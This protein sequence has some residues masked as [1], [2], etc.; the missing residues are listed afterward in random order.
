MNQC[1]AS[2]AEHAENLLDA[3]L[4]ELGSVLDVDEMKRLSGIQEVWIAYRD[5][6]CE[7]QASD[8]PIEGRFVRRARD[9]GPL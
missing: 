1:F 3:L 9:D 7:W 2:D 8:R 4:K 6:H 5:A